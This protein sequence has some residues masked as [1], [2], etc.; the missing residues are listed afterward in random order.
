MYGGKVVL[1]I[2][3]ILRRYS[4]STLYKC[5]PPLRLYFLNVDFCEHSFSFIYGLG[6][7]DDDVMLELLKS[8]LLWCARTL[9]FENLFCSSNVYDIGCI[10]QPMKWH[11]IYMYNQSN[12]LR[13]YDTNNVNNIGCTLVDLYGATSPQETT[14]VIEMCC[15]IQPKQIT[16]L[17]HNNRWNGSLY[18]WTN[19]SVISKNQ[20]Y[21]PE[22]E[23][24][25]E[26]TENPKV[27]L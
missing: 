14:D 27:F 26:T 25:W 2:N 9:K 17:V 23:F 5:C 4:K 10:I 22:M 12:S 13:L 19:Q 3:L 16:R 24:K 15:I 11:F 8:S 7:S 21:L 1:H 6:F 18:S 20:K